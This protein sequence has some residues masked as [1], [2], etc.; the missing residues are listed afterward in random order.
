M[1]NAFFSSSN[2]ATAPFFSRDVFQKNGRFSETLFRTKSASIP[3]AQ[4][5][6][7]SAGV[8][9]GGSMVPPR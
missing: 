8:R 5:G 1:L 6:A 7:R 3:P 2:V 9:R 4:G